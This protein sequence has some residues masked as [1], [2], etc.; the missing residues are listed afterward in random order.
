[1]RIQT[2]SLHIDFNEEIFDISE[3]LESTFVK[4]RPDP[5]RRAIKESIRIL[6]KDSEN[7]LQNSIGYH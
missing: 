6:I 5:S 4:S 3:Y 2:E 1:M 7:L